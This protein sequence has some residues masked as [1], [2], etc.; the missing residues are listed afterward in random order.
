MPRGER[1]H[2]AIFKGAIVGGLFAAVINLVLFFGSAHLGG[3]ILV[4]HPNSEEPI[5]LPIL[6]PLFGTLFLAMSA[7]FTLT[8]FLR[9]A[10][11]IYW[12]LF[13][14]VTAIVCTLL[15]RLA[16]GAIL[17]NDPWS[18]AATAGMFVFG[19]GITTLS[20]YLHLRGQR[21]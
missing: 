14:I 6:M 5:Q 19:S 20:M 8:T 10:P 1:Q 12:P 15:A 3:D 9:Y 2:I 17:S 7:A 13:L 21:S 16:V 11:R 18:I 4:M